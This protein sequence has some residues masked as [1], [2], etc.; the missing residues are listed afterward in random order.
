MR[1]SASLGSR[2]FLPESLSHSLGWMVHVGG[3]FPESVEDKLRGWNSTL[4]IQK[5]TDSP[6]TR[7]L[8]EYKDSTFGRKVP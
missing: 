5:E 6:S 1:L 4:V 7:G 3:D 2:L 8:L